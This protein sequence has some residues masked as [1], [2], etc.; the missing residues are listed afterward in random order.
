MTK[1][2]YPWESGALQTHGDGPYPFSKA[3]RAGDFVFLSG[4]IAWGEDG[5]V[6]IGG[7]ED[8]TRQTWLNI[9]RT[10]EEVGCSL[11]DVVKATIWLQDPRDFAGYNKVY[12]EFFPSN[13]PTRSTVSANLIFDSMASTSTNRFMV[14]R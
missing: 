6:I 13:P 14:R 4:Q 1:T 8:Q 2:I 7:I 3:I 5:R 9:S 11:E 10:L 12:A